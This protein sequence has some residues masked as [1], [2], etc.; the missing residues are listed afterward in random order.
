MPLEPPDRQR[1]EC[2]S[3]SRELCAVA[4]ADD[5]EDRA[6]PELL[7]KEQDLLGAT[8]QGNPI[9][10]VHRLLVRCCVLFSLG[11]A[12]KLDILSQCFGEVG[13]LFFI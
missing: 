10:V 11:Q 4:P 8:A 5:G 12:V 7:R 1:P 6:E 3:D 9:L 2:F 13:N